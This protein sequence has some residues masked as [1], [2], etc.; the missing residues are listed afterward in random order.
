M[1]IHTLSRHTVKPPSL[2]EFFGL[3]RVDFKLIDPSTFAHVIIDV[4]REFCDPEYGNQGSNHTRDI[5]QK[6]AEIKPHFT[7]A[8]VQTVI[9]YYA[10]YGREPLDHSRGGLYLVK[11]DPNDLQLVKATD[12]A[13]ADDEIADILKARNIKNLL[14][15][16]FNAGACVYTSVRDG[17]SKGF[18]IALL[19]DCI[20]QNGHNGQYKV[21]DYIENMTE[22]GVC[23]MTA[24]QALTS[25]S[26]LQGPAL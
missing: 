7:R 11:K 5:S 14:V 20:G 24:D 13:F 19:E 17:L 2:A 12:S 23:K 15:S 26:A 3:D 16:G 22:L 18:R 25:L 6:I 9:I 8:G 4:Q 10:E 21:S 1:P